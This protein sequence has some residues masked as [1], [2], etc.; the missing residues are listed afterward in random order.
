MNNKKAVQ[1]AAEH[2][3]RVSCCTTL[4]EPRAPPAPYHVPLRTYG[5]V[6]TRYALTWYK[7]ETNSIVSGTEYDTR[8]TIEWQKDPRKTKKDREKL[9]NN[10]SKGGA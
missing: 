6:Y 8:Y 1:P 2:G 4:R 9:E 3:Q 7:K 5:M 10:A